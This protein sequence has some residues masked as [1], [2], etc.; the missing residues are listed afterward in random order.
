M[1]VAPSPLRPHDVAVNGRLGQAVVAVGATALC[2]TVWGVSSL[3]NDGRLRSILIVPLA[4]T[5]F[6]GLAALLGGVVGVIFGHPAEEWTRLGMLAVG[7]CAAMVSVLFIGIASWHDGAGHAIN[8]ALQVVAALGFW[9]SIA[10]L[11][12]AI[13]GELPEIGMS[14]GD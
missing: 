7:V 10:A 14:E 9:V 2:L 4:V 1:G 5:F 8:V 11:G 12:G 6:W 3:L 13:F